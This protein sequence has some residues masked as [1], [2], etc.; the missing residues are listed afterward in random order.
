MFL[1]GKTKKKTLALIKM[2]EQCLEIENDYV[3]RTMYIVRILNS[4]TVK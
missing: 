4:S 2:Y 3:V 1:Y